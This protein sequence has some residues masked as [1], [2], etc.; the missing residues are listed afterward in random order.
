MIPITSWYILILLIISRAITSETSKNFSP[1]A[2]K[3]SSDEKLHSTNSAADQPHSRQ[4]RLIWVADDGRLALPPGTS[5]VIAPTLAMPFIRYPPDGFHSNISI[6]LPLTI[7]FDKL[8]LTDNQNPL[9]T[10]GPFFGRSMG[11][12]AGSILADYVYK[13]LK[14]RTKR[15]IGNDFM[16]INQIENEIPTLPDEHKHAFHGG[17]RALLYAVL[18]DFLSNFG[19]DGHNCLLRAIC[20]VHS[21]SIHRYGLFG[22]FLKLF[23]TAS[24]SPYSKLLS[25]YVEAEK[26]GKEVSECL[27]YYKQCPKSIFKSSSISS[28][29]RNNAFTINS[30]HESM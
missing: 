1:K 14:H 8:G 11:R 9:G 3:S 29:T 2:P 13:F 26:M 7:D 17:E 24:L 22:E 6:S 12:S 15:D 4:K 18:E 20:E 21:K 27:P 23:F 19:L 25:E 16:K 5:L 30:A 10:L 28:M